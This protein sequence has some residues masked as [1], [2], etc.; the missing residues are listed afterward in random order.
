MCAS[1]FRFMV[2]CYFVNALW[3][4]E[5]QYCELAVSLKLQESKWRVDHNT[6]AWPCTL[7]ISVMPECTLGAGINSSGIVGK[8]T[9]IITYVPDVRIITDWCI[10]C[11]RWKLC[12]SNG[13]T[14]QHCFS[15]LF[16]G[17]FLELNRN[18]FSD[19]RRCRTF[20][21]WSLVKNEI[22]L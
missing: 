18:S 10:V 5:I 16:A 20:R 6:A 14:T 21:T 3:N 9:C 4:L 8:R 13:E 22:V 19:S 11:M 7:G 12:D 17:N 15:R 2:L 1:A